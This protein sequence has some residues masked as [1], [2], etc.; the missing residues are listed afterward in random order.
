MGNDN[1]YG[2]YLMACYNEDDEQFQTVC[3]LGTGFTDENLQ[4]FT[5]SMT[6]VPKQ[7]KSFL[8]SKQFLARS[9]P[10]V[11]FEPNRVWEVKAADLS[12]S[13]VHT[14][15]TGIVDPSKG[16]ALRFPRFIRVRDD[17]NP[18]ESTSSTQVA[19]FYNDQALT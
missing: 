7:K 9:P 6:V 11:W 8:V 4:L 1:R 16:V 19:Q 5:S 13:P 14:A 15:A 18:E 10:D 12:I 3:K 2:A 17:K